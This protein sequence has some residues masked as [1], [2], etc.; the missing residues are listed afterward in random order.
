MKGWLNDFPGRGHAAVISYALWQSAFSGNRSVIGRAIKLNGKTYRITAVMPQGISLNDD[1]DVWVPVTIAAS[2]RTADPLYFMY[3][4]IGRLKPEATD[5]ALQ[6]Q[7][8][9]A[10]REIVA[11][12]PPKRL[13]R[14]GYQLIESPVEPDRSS[15][16]TTS[17][18]LLQAAVLLVLL[19]ACI[20]VANLLLSRILG[21]GHE[22]AMRSALG[23]SNGTLARQL[24]VEALC[25]SVPGGVVGVALGWLCLKFTARNWRPVS[26]A[27]LSTCASACSRSAW[28]A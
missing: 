13:Q 6:A 28:C 4:L 27:R 7:L 12:A 3:H 26:R 24:L 15:A 11:I 21:R 5:A 19:I 9:A 20:N 22:L 23:A 10:R 2:D 17:L 18:L 25:L 1:V 16:R 8:Q 14:N